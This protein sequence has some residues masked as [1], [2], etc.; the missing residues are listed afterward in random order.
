VQLE[1]DRKTQIH[2]EQ[3]VVDPDRGCGQH[4]DQLPERV[5]F[6]GQHDLLPPLAFRLPRASPILGVAES[7]SVSGAKGVAPKLQAFVSSFDN[8]GGVERVGVIAG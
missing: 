5:D 3:P 6:P 2:F 1:A 8:T 4:V 7:S